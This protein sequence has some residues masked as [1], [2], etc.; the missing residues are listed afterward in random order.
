MTEEKY[1]RLSSHW[2][3]ASARL[4]ADL[5]PWVGYTLMDT[6]RQGETLLLRCPVICGCISNGGNEVRLEAINP[7]GLGAR[8]LL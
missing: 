8:R 4:V 1:G 3:N 7:G 2:S 6:L 5:S